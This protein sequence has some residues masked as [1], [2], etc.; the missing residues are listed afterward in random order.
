MKCVTC[1]WFAPKTS[2]EGETITLGRCRK[3]APTMNG[4]PVVFIEDWCGQHKL[5]ET[6]LTLG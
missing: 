4:Y 5:D 2:G 1:M 3:N 6:K